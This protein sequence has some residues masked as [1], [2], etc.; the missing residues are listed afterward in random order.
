M[1]LGIDCDRPRGELDLP[2]RGG[3]GLEKQLVFEGS[4]QKSP[5]PEIDRVPGPSHVPFTNGTTGLGSPL[6]GGGRPTLAVSWA[7]KRFDRGV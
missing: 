3:L 5:C 6:E 4:V 7:V 1:G 2:C